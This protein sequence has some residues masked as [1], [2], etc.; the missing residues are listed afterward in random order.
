[1]ALPHISNSA[2]GTNRYDPVHNSIFEVTFDLPNALK[3]AFDSDRLL[4]TQH[5]LKISGLDAL[6]RAPEADIQK[7]M[8]TS[9]SYIK[10]TVGDTHA[11][12][13]VTFS[14]NL[15]DKTDNYIL[16]LFR[17]WAALGYDISTGKRTIKQNYCSDWM[18]VSIANRD[19]DIYQEIIFKDVM[20]SGPLGMSGELDYTSDDAM[21]L[22]V[23]FRSDWWS[24]LN[25]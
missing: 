5:V 10:P 14:L 24:E 9:R 1:M 8:G 22:T 16:K 3:S 25:A 6:Y 12:L 19:G 23:K 15:R 20:I 18:K 7:F 4:L 11:E 2:A 17:A 21:E 13:E